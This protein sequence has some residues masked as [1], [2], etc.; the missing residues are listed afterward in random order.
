MEV[1]V[2]LYLLCKTLVNSESFYFH[3]KITINI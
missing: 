1:Y 2:E 3:K